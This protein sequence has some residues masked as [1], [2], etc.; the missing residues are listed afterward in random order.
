MAAKELPNW[1][2]GEKDCSEDVI[3]R[4]HKEALALL[5]AVR[6]PVLKDTLAATLHGGAVVRL[7]LGLTLNYSASGCVSADSV[8]MPNVTKAFFNWFREKFPQATASSCTI[9][10][11]RLATL[12]VDKGNIGLSHLTCLG[13]FT[14]GELWVAGRRQASVLQLQSHRFLCF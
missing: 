2:F 4:G 13:D 12:H 9:A 1:T 5:Q 8:R 6:L 11:N 7:Q 3:I 10:F 14:G